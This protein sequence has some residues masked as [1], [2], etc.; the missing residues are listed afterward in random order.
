[1]LFVTEVEK[2]AESEADDEAETIALALNLKCEALAEIDL[3]KE[4]VAL[5]EGV[6]LGAGVFDRDFDTDSVSE[7]VREGVSLKLGVALKDAVDSGVGLG[8][9]EREA[10]AVDDIFSDTELTRA[11]IDSTGVAVAL[12]EREALAMLEA[13]CEIA[14][15][16]ESRNDA[17]TNGLGVAPK[18][19]V[20]CPMKVA[21]AVEVIEATRFVGEIAGVRV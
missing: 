11:E 8:E 14:D 9:G 5:A 13:V 2:D 17:V 15:D 10:I 12:A 7:L 19:S 6:G 4:E 21:V 16:A 3:V 1:M 18:V 20:Y